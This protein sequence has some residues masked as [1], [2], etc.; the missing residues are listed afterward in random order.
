[1]IMG[2]SLFSVLSV[3]HTSYPSIFGR[4]ISKTTR[5]GCLI[6]MSSSAES[7]SEYPISEK[8]SSFKY[9]RTK[10]M[11][12]ASSSTTQIRF[13]SMKIVFRSWR[14]LQ[15]LPDLLWVMRQPA[16]LTELE[17]H[18]ERTPHIQRSSSE[19]LLYHSR[20]HLS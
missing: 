14:S 2:T 19:N 10:S 11:I 8:P 12:L 20:R 3:L 15:S 17:G 4:M 16:L 13:T 5:A 9:I 6:L 7:R 18:S 1:M